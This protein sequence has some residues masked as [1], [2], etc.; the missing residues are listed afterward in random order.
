MV[1]VEIAKEQSIAVCVVEDVDEVWRVGRWTR[2][3]VDGVD[4]NGDVIEEYKTTDITPS[5]EQTC[6]L[7]LH[8][9]GSR[10]IDR[11]SID[12]FFIVS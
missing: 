7:G 5:L 6:L 8:H 12:L 11:N 9:P 10:V 2:R 3:G 1:G 4:G